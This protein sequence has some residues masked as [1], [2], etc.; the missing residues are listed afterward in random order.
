ML[1]KAIAFLPFSWPL[2]SSLL[3]LPNT[4]ETRNALIINSVQFLAETKE[5]TKNSTEH[6]SC[7]PVIIGTL[8]VMLHGTFRD[9]DF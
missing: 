5:T 8:Y 3:K 1:I 2:P 4:M 7:S 9:D 6:A